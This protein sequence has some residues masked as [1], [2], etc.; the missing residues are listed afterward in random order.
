MMLPYGNTVCIE[1]TLRE[2]HVM[3]QMA[4]DFP[5]F[6]HYA[7]EFCSRKRTYFQF[8][9]QFDEWKFSLDLTK[10]LYYFV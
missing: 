5:P 6:F 2:Q 1:K 10:K 4:L 8:N 3:K 9:Q 7:M